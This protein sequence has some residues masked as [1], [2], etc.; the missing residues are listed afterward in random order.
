MN[1]W[2][3]KFEAKSLDEPEQ[4]Q[5]QEQEIE[6]QE[7]K[8]K[9][10]HTTL[11]QVTITPLSIPHQTV[12]T[13]FETPT[14]EIPNHYNHQN[15]S[16][17][18]HNGNQR[19]V[20]IYFILII[21]I[22]ILIYFC[23][24]IYNR[25]KA[26]REAK[27][28]N[29]SNYM[30]DHTTITD[31]ESLPQTLLG[32]PPTL[33]NQ[34]D[35]DTN[36]NISNVM[37]LNKPQLSVPSTTSIARPNTGGSMY[38]PLSATSTVLKLDRRMISNSSEPIS[39]TGTP[40]Y[41]SVLQQQ[42]Q[43]SRGKEGNFSNPVSSSVVLDLFVRTGELPSYTKVTTTASELGKDES[44]STSTSTSTNTN[45]NTSTM[46]GKPILPP[47]QIHVVPK[48]VKLKHSRKLLD[49]SGRPNS[50]SN[51]R[52][53][54]TVPIVEENSGD[55]SS[56]EGINNSANLKQ[57]QQ[58]V[59]GCANKPALSSPLRTQISDYDDDDDDELEE[60]EDGS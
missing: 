21:F 50:D 5:E 32:D 23:G 44:T 59:C 45:T 60:E 43:Q 27:L 4:E 48:R 18:N 28:V 10:T 25:L 54:Y 1:S 52:N 8:E 47:P 14:I 53:G 30:T 20:H 12:E 2:E 31:P 42:Q 38:N 56:G 58:S 33:Q 35:T 15:K 6:E 7:V 36:Y 55:C 37:S 22:L 46:L 39:V 24:I 9:T 13:S 41:Y 16:I 34:Q 3:F 51:M 26:S 40:S 17:S 19:A 49:R 11:I 29:N 57:Q